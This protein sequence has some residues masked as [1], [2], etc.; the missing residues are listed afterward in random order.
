[1]KAKQNFTLIE[2][3]VVIAIIAI[4][5]AMLLP[6]L[7]QA[8]ERG[9]A[10]SCLNNLKQMHLGYVSYADTYNDVI[11]GIITGRGTA[12]E[13]YWDWVL[14]PFLE[15]NTT[16]S[17][18]NRTQKRRYNCPS[19]FKTDTTYGTT[20]AQVNVP[21]LADRCWRYS[22]LKRPSI[23]PQNGDSPAL[24]GS[25][26]SRF[27]CTLEKQVPEGRHNGGAN[28]LFA[29]GHAGYGKCVD[30]QT[31]WNG[32]SLGWPRFKEVTWFTSSAG[33]L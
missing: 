33:V 21:G 7:N 9:R 8:R 30:T 12:G 16:Q 26:Y 20:L 3:L 29:D 1:M 5:A 2:L 32:T 23:Q 4:L 25:W 31:T 19:A 18:D 11:P 14:S 10:T 6:A 22:R 13:R 24:I 17:Y 15:G 27:I 28:I